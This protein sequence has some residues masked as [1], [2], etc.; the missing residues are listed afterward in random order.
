M[1]TIKI[2]LSYVFLMLMILLAGCK[3][4][5]MEVKVE[6]RFAQVNAAVSTDPR[7][8][9]V[10]LTLS[11]NGIASINPGG[12]IMW[13]ATYKIRG[14]TLTIKVQEIDSEFRFTIVSD[15]ELSGSN[16][17]VLKLVK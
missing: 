13:S 1:K 9:G 2:K 15:Q 7:F 16:G 10:T 5:A 17:E 11:P 6:K 4:D 3:K 8:G 14:N 12:D